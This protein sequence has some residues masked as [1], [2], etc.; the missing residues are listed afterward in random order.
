MTGKLGWRSAESKHERHW[1]EIHANAKHGARPKSQAQITRAVKR[2][3]ATDEHT[4]R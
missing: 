2:E 1:N 3:D 4:E